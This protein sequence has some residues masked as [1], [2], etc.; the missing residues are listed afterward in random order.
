[1]YH[2]LIASTSCTLP[3]T[4]AGAGCFHLALSL[5]IPSQ[6]DAARL[7]RLEAEITVAVLQVGQ[8][9]RLN[10]SRE[11]VLGKVERLQGVQCEYEGR[12]IC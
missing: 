11:C 7:A 4:R 12:D 6:K 10:D 8:H 9:T 1:M 5:V 2:R 3:G